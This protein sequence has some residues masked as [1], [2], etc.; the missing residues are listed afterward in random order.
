M[1]QVSDRLAKLSA[2][3]TIAMNQKSKD[4]QAQGID[5]INLSVG[6]P[7]F[8][9]PDHI[10]AAAKKAIDDN[11]SFYPPVAGYPALRNAIV[12]K[13]KKQNG[14]DYTADQIT[15]SNGAKHSIVNVL[16]CIIN[17]GDEVIIPAPYWVSYAEQVK[18]SEGTNVILDT[19]IEDD[20]KVTPEQV[21]NAITPKTRAIMLCSPSN[22][23]GS[24]YSKDEL[25]AIAD[26]LAEHERIIIISDEIY[27]HINYI[28]KHESIAQFSNVKDRVVLVNGVSK[29]YAMTGW[30]LGYIAAPLWIAKAVTKLQGQFTSGATA[31][32][33]IASITALT[34]DQGP[35]QEM[36]KA[37]KRRRDLV[38]GHLDTIDGVK[39]SIPEG[40]F[41][42][43]PDMS[44]Y[45]GKSVEGQEIKDS[46]DLCMYLLES[47]HIATVP[48]S[49]FGAPDCI[50][51]S[52]ANSDENLEEAMKRLKNALAKMS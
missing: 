24:V 46:G 51:I 19:V 10:K 49:A 42:V 7:D 20:F 15:V 26:V 39:C 43:F 3:A 29:A 48:G 36:N 44:Q 32:A 23:T 13:L 18:I 47:G 8:N 41:Y 11:Y 30:R 12:D 34:G 16:L 28:G 50:R 22:P 21:K 17:E 52:F 9:M 1:E 2:S 45:F 38:L 5:V 6:E 14:L 33:Q 31:V 25:E 40:A 27:E 35:T 37:F 4:L